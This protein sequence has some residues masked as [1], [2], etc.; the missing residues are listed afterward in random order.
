MKKAQSRKCQSILR[1]AQKSVR[2]W[3]SCHTLPHVLIIRG[4]NC[5]P[6]FLSQIVSMTS[7]HHISFEPNVAAC[8]KKVCVDVLMD[9]IKMDL[10]IKNTHLTHYQIFQR[11]PPKQAPRQLPCGQKNKANSSRPNMS[12][13]KGWF[14]SAAQYNPDYVHQLLGILVSSYIL[15]IM[16]NKCNSMYP[17]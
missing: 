16:N 15:S 11:R 14:L 3:S 4:L 2:P 6:I 12:P 17:L 10:R 1:T 7:F 13:M 5:S 8:V 9:S